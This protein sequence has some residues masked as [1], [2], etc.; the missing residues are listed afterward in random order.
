MSLWKF[1]K[2]FTVISNLLVERY[3]INL[4]APTFYS[5]SSDVFMLAEIHWLGG[6]FLHR[7]LN[8]WMARVFIRCAARKLR[9][10]NHS[11]IFFVEYFL[12][13]RW[14]SFAFRCCHKQC[15]Y[16]WWS[17]RCAS[18]SDKTHQRHA[19]VCACFSY[20]GLFKRFYDN[21]LFCTLIC[22]NRLQQWFGTQ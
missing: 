3:F 4:W 20:T 7:L 18:F 19:I 9:D 21:C 2:K 5:L 15:K 6:N 12:K 1:T 11:P 13:R 17:I 10:I 16:L 14:H 8:I 22:R